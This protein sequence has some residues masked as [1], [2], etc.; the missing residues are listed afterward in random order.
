[1]ASLDAW[2]NRTAC[3]ILLLRLSAARITKEKKIKYY[4]V[5]YKFLKLELSK[6]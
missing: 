2:L 6:H 1:M 5:K 3:G 4:D